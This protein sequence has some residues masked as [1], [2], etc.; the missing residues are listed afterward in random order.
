MEKIVAVAMITRR[1]LLEEPGTV[2]N[3]VWWYL[4]LHLARFVEIVTVVVSFFCW[5]FLLLF[6]LQTDIQSLPVS[7]RDQIEMYVTSSI[8]H[9]FARVSILGV[10]GYI[11]WCSFC[12]ENW[13]CLNFD[14]SCMFYFCIEIFT[15]YSGIILHLTV[16]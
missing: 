3:L 15:R 10:D 13:K 16:K 1:L 2:C 4:L 9:A 5:K 8:K 11:W 6:L 14:S 12:Y 7:D